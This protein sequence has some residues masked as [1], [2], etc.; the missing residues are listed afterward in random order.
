MRASAGSAVAL[1]RPKVHPGAV[2]QLLSLAEEAYESGN[3]EWAEDVVERIYTAYDDKL[4]GRSGVDH[5]D[6]RLR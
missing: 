1:L 5:P 3:T 4:G 6:A 2:E